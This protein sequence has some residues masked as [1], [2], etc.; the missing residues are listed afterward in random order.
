MEESLYTRSMRVEDGENFEDLI[1]R[2]DRALTFL[3]ER[4]EASLAVV[5]HGFFLRTLV[6]RAVFADL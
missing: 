6:A 4:R 1:A 3:G 5:T 2:A